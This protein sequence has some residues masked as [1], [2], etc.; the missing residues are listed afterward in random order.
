VA[1]S[2]SITFPNIRPKNIFFRIKFKKKIHHGYYRPWKKTF[3]P[4]FNLKVFLKVCQ[5]KKIVGFLEKIKGN[6]RKK[7]LSA[8]ASSAPV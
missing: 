2:G 4:C 6:S 1:F 8:W 7:A 3:Q 5:G